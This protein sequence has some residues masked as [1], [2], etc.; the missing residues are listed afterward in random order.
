MRRPSG[1]NCAFSS[2]RVEPLSTEAEDIGPRVG[3]L[4]LGLLRRHVRYGSDN[5]AIDGDGRRTRGRECRRFQRAPIDE[6]R[7]AEIEQL[8]L[9]V[10][11]HRDVRRFQVAMDDAA[12][13]GRR[14]RVGDLEPVVERIAKAEAAP[15]NDA[16]ECAA[17]DELHRR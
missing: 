10:I 3:A 9:T 15:R 16:I 7:Q 4:A 8:D 2:D 6:L 11:R 5:R 14:D 13:V 12:G 1:E 17:G